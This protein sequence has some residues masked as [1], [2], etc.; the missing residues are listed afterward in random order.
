VDGNSVYWG[1]SSGHAIQKVPLAGG[2]AADLVTG[3]DAQYL[4]SD[5]TNVYWSDFS[6]QGGAF[7][8]VPVGGGTPTVLATGLSNPGD[9]AVDGTNV[10]FANSSTLFGTK[11]W[12]V[13]QGGATP[14]MVAMTTDF[15][16]YEIAVDAT[17]IYW[18]ASNKIGKAALAGGSVETIATGQH[19]ALSIAV[20]A[21]N[22]YWLNTDST[23]EAVM[24]LAK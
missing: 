5:G 18:A 17:I 9:I 2:T 19:G 14:A 8:R 3:T 21:T 11:F 16:V 20:D 13:P 15:A 7:V 22:V 1:G 23:A 6:M 24:K 12:K 10:Y 4:A